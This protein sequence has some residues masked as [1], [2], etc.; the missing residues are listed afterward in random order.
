MSRVYYHISHY[1]EVLR[2]LFYSQKVYLRE[3]PHDVPDANRM[4]WW[5]PIVIARGDNLD[6]NNVTPA[7]WMRDRKELT[8]KDMPDADQFI[9]INPEEIGKYYID[10]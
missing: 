2:L 10:F 6:F 4:S 7:V 8:L 5:A 3:R 9:I 1:I